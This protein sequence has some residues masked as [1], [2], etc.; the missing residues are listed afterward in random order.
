MTARQ[1]NGTRSAQGGD[2]IKENG[3]NVK[4]KNDNQS[5]RVKKKT[6]RP[7][8][9]SKTSGAISTDPKGHI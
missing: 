3:E 7:R 1:N 6:I 2:M 5:R 8:A 9:K 4:I